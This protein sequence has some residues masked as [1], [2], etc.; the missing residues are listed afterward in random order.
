MLTALSAGLITGAACAY[1]GV[2]IIL[3]RVVFMGI[4]L[5]EVAALGVALGLFIGIN[6]FACASALTL[7]GV[8]IFWAAHAERSLSR[9]SFIGFI[10]VFCAS[11]AVLLIAKNPMAEARGINLI[12]GNLLYAKWQD[13]AVLGIAV[14]LVMSVHLAFF[15][16]F[17][18]I[19]FDKETA[20]TAGVSANAL[21]LLLYV[22]IGIMISLA[23]KTCGVI[24]VFASLLVPAM[25][26]LVFAR[27]VRSIFI[28]ACL[29]ACLCVTAGLALSYLW[30]LPTSPVIVVL[31]GV[32]FASAA[33]IKR[34]AA[35]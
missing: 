20:F 1:L 21:D 14:F 3:K 26:G 25:I 9:E 32:F 33:G 7:I 6:P 19:S 4:A 8:I 22:T 31:Y 10:Y 5:A 29:S 11:L 35:K 30:D 16:K 23:T 2:Y 17:L 13:V 18:F 28:I 12:S 27:R 24:F 34:I 15:K